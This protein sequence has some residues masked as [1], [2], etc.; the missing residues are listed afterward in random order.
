MDIFG[1]LCNGVRWA[2]SP[3]DGRRPLAP[4]GRL[5]SPRGGP[6]AVGLHPEGMQSTALG[7]GW[8]TNPKGEG[9]HHTAARLAN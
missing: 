2:P 9:P 6:L 8:P 5:G 3:L 1:Q 4:F 7:R